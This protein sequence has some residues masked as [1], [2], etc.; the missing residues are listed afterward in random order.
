MTRERG[1]LLTS[2]AMRADEPLVDALDGEQRARET[3]TGVPLS[4]GLLVRL[5]AEEA[6]GLRAPPPDAVARARARAC[7]AIEE[8]RRESI[9]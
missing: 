3:A 4:R 1:K 6:L 2:V 5:L 8:T 7:T 9:S